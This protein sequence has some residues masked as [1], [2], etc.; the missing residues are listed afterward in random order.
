MRR[1][2]STPGEE[3]HPMPLADIPKPIA[4]FFRALA[5]QNRAALVAALTSDAIA[6][7]S[8]TD[9]RGAEAVCEWL[10][11]LPAASAVAEPV[12]AR[13]PGVSMIL[14]PSPHRTDTEASPSGP[15]HVSW[16]FTL[17][18]D[19]IAAIALG[20]EQRL[21][22]PEPVA[23]FIRATNAVELHALLE[24]FADHALVNDQL[25]EHWDKPSIAQ[26]AA[27]DVIA[28]RLSMQVGTVVTYPEQ[29][30]VTANLAG[31]FDKRPMRTPLAGTFYSWTR[32][33]TT[34]PRATL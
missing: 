3:V 9:H 34:M 14:T 13:T 11:G 1:A 33:N 30:V 16:S 24:T 7:D 22:L 26:W 15:A 12:V 32:D 19:K 8:G 6:T 5:V 28:Q 10:L 17:A 31:P 29:A 4:A 18:G 23:A 21:D 20:D 25:R 2:P 27:R